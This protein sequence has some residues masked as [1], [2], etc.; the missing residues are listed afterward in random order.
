MASA[1]SA[2]LL[3]SATVSANT[4]TQQVD[5]QEQQIERIIVTGQKF[6]R[7]LQETTTSVAVVTAQD[8]EQQNITSFYDALTITANTH[9][10]ADGS[11]SIRGINGTNVSGGGNS[12]LA[13]VYVDGASLPR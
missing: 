9:A 13:S 12:Y 1:I 2:G 4:D 11:F 5:E 7:T 8:I 3:L 6:A 10:T